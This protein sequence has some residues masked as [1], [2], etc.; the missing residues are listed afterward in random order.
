MQLPRLISKNLTGQT[1]KRS[2]WSRSSIL[3][4]VSS[5]IKPVRL[6]LLLYQCSGS[7]CSER[8][9]CGVVDTYY[10]KIGL[11][12]DLPPH[13]VIFSR[14][15]Q[16]LLVECQRGIGT[17]ARFAL[18]MRKAV[19]GTWRFAIIWI[20]RSSTLMW[21]LRCVYTIDGGNSQGCW[22]RVDWC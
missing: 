14:E 13:S 15:V 6:R 5:P 10:L 9:W 17:K 1:P 18:R 4:H 22:R 2:M 8:N 11:P 3:K 19:S 12:S 16:Y 7:V 21:S 20:K